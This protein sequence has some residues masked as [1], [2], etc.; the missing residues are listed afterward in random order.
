MLAPNTRRWP[1]GRALMVTTV[2]AA[3]AVGLRIAALLGSAAARS[4]TA[5][6][7][8]APT[9]AADASTLSNGPS[10]ILRPDD[11]PLVAVSLQVYAATGDEPA[12]QSGS[13]HLLEYLLL[14]GTEH[15]SEEWRCEAVARSSVVSHESPTP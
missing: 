12:G 3:Q 5:P 1:R 15:I 2:R 10:V 14:G 9:P 6:M 8:A 11:S 7:P 4:S 13:A